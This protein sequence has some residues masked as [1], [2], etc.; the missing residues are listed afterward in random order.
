MKTLIGYFCS[1]CRSVVLERYR[2]A[3]LFCPACKAAG[4]NNSAIEPSAVN[5][6]KL[7]K[8][9]FPQD[10]KENKKQG[11]LFQEEPQNFFPGGGLF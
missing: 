11:K 10:V 4:S 8:N 9:D 6:I 3:P 2:K 7:D 1:R 5:V